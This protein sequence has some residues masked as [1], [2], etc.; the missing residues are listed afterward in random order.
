MLPHGRNQQA[1]HAAFQRGHG[2]A[3]DDRPTGEVG[4][5]EQRDPPLIGPGSV[6]L[7][8]EFSRDDIRVGVAARDEGRAQ[9]G[10]GKARE[11]SSLSVSATRGEGDGVSLGLASTRNARQ[12]K[13][14][15]DRCSG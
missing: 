2:R 9:E 4:R 14:R 12:R 10:V 7:T 6:L 5:G 11:E 1:E 13:R 3:R 8:S 15:R